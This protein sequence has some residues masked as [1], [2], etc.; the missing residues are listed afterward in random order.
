LA[1]VGPAVSLPCP[2]TGTPHHRATSPS[3]SL[4]RDFVAGLAS[5]RQTFKAQE[6]TEAAYGKKSLK[7]TRIYE[8]VKTVKEGKTTVDQR[9]NNGRRKVTSPDFVA[10][11]AA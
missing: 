10:E 4:I 8:T 1:A 5:S 3:I 6:T 9:Q 2:L 7:N 11:I